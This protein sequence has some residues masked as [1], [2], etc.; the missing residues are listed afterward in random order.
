MQSYVMIALT[1]DPTKCLGPCCAKH[2]PLPQVFYRLEG[3]RWEWLGVV[4]ERGV[5]R[6]LG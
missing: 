6:V 1:G 2:Q 5:Q 4:F 3:R